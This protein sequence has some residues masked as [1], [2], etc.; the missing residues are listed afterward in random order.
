MATQP[1]NMKKTAR[2]TRPLTGLSIVKKKTRETVFKCS[3][4]WK[5]KLSK[6]GKSQPKMLSP[7]FSDEGP[8]LDV[9]YYYIANCS[10]KILIWL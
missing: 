1:T 7:N 4:S 3:N 10:S 9:L 2:F 6:S 5:K 8:D